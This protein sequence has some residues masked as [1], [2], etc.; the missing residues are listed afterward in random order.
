MKNNINNMSDEELEIFLDKRI[1]TVHQLINQ[2]INLIK[3]K[4]RKNHKFKSNKQRAYYINNIYNYV[5]WV[6]EQI[7]MNEN[8][9]RDAKVIP[10]RGEIWTC[11]LGQN[12]GSEENKIRPV[13]IIQNDTGNKNAPTTIIAPISNR[14]K[15][16]AVHIEL[17]ESDYKLENGEKNHITGTVLLEQI[18]V[19][20]KA[21]LGRHI[22]TLN[23][24]FMDIL[25]SKIKISLNL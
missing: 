9:S 24:E 22:A 14:P 11:E 4:T 18:K 8:V 1:E 12:I 25:D 15:K 17:R 7:K 6:N 5:S 16:I 13:I 21:R 23:N 19:V 2:Y 20:S 3:D 10:R